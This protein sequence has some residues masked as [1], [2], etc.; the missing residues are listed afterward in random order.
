MSEE[1]KPTEAQE[2]AAPAKVEA[3]YE[4]SDGE[5]KT[6]CRQRI[7]PGCD[8]GAEAE[9]VRLRALAELDNT[10]KRLEKE[11]QEFRKFACENVLGQLLPV[12]D[13][14]DLALKHSPQEDG[15]KNFVLGVDMTRKAFLDVLSAN[16]MVP[17]GEANEAFT[18][19]RHEAV[20]Q[21][22]REDLD[23]G[24]VTQVMQ[25]GYLLNGRLLRPA[26]V[27]VSKKPE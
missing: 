22:E 16:G 13:N 20:G 26:K 15:C 25:R 11:K 6:L 9:D 1:N 17:V 7:C 23:E 14:L 21:D 3:P 10:R 8:I 4:P 27:M 24:T 18:P 2:T 12:L 5:L 19:E